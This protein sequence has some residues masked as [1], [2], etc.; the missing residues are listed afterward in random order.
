MLIWLFVD[1]VKKYF[2]DIILAKGYVQALQTKALQFLVRWNM[3]AK[4]AVDN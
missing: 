1:E 3:G 2:N 4:T